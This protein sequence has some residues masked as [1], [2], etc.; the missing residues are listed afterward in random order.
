MH[1]TTSSGHPLGWYVWHP[2]CGR[3]HGRIVAPY[4]AGFAAMAWPVGHNTGDHRPA[5]LVATVYRITG[6]YPRK[7]VTL[8]ALVPRYG[9]RQNNRIMLK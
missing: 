6:F 7:G 3:L 9:H 1:A 4:G 2:P 8:P 5:D